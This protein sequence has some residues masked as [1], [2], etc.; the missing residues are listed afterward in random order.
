MVIGESK[1]NE[2][3][4]FFVVQEGAVQSSEHRIFDSS[5]RQNRPE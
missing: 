2:E 1:H 4:L 5:H 3:E